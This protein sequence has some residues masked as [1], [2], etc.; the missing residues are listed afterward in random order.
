LPLV[1]LCAHLS[2]LDWDTCGVFP[3]M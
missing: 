2:F 1:S 3:T